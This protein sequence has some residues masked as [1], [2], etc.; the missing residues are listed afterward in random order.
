MPSSFFILPRMY[1]LRP[2]FSTDIP[3]TSLPL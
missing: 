3:V 1:H 2:F